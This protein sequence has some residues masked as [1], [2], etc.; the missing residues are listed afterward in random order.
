MTSQLELDRSRARKQASV[1]QKGRQAWGASS[2]SAQGSCQP[3]PSL[4][5]IIRQWPV[6]RLRCSARAKQ[7]TERTWKSLRRMCLVAVLLAQEHELIPVTLSPTTTRA[8]HV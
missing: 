1:P 8:K 7:R 2:C 3:S 6:D 4:G 5:S